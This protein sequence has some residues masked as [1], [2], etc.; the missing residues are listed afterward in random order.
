MIN[1]FRVQTILRI[2]ALSVSLAV[3]IYLIFQTEYLIS[4]VLLGIIIV[5]QVVALVR[6]IET[7]NTK[8]VRFLEAINYND[9]SLTFL[10]KKN[11]DTFYELGEAFNEVIEKFKEERT[12][13]EESHRYLETV[14]QHIGIGLFSYN[15]DGNI[16]L[17]NTAAKRLLNT[18]VL[19][20]VIQL[21]D[22]DELLYNSVMELKSGS[23]TLLNIQIEAERLQLAM[24]ATE[25]RMKGENYKLISLQNISSELDEK[26]MEAW[27]N[28]T[29]VLAHEIMN[30]I[31]PIASLSDTVN[32]MLLGD[33]FGSESP[34]PIPGET[35]DD[36]KE[37]LSTI[38]KRSL[39]LMRFVNS[40]RN[41]TQL[42]TPAFE[43]TP[44]RDILKRVSNLMM[45]EATRQRVNVQVS[46][47]PDS[48]EVTADPQLIE[49][50]LINIVKNAFKALVEVDRPELRLRS[51]I[52]GSGHAIIEV[53][54]NGPGI[55][56]SI[57]DKIFVP[58]YSTS[59][60][61]EVGGGSGIGL[62][63]SRQIMRMHGG[64]L[65][66]TTTEPGKT[67]F[68]LRF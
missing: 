4:A 55:K 34:E 65:T 40:Y 47:E 5:L 62:S 32:T 66:V 20:N 63:L 1:G 24:Y 35:L 19:R 41:I 18:N 42:P 43:V 12:K 56:D 30:S 7:T 67:I 11:K 31:T 3:M 68:Q 22:I 51:K 29:Q 28:L 53:E 15:Q 45:G 27:Q 37:A 14:V 38:N 21:K 36:V 64:S 13:G 50:A 10:N 9:F 17:L 25:F 26:E 23:R 6:Y 46:V 49:Q 58:F 61:M 54:D 16:E 59:K 33:I 39:G 44:V 52:D 8:L 57:L 2:V 48:L 60:S